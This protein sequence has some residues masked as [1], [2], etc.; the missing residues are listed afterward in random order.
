MDAISLT[1]PCYPA[2]PSKAGKWRGHHPVADDWV[3]EPKLNGWRAW[4]H[5]PTGAMFN[6]HG[7][8]LSIGDTYEEVLDDLRGCSLEWLDSEA[9]ERRHGILR[10]SLVILDSPIPGDYDERQNEI[11]LSLCTLDRFQPLPPYSVPVNDTGKILSFAYTFS[12]KDND[13]DLQPNQ[14]WHRLQEMNRVLGCTFYEGFVAKKRRAPYPR[15][16][17]PE[18]ATT[19]WVKFRWNNA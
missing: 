8:R 15:A 1:P 12:E 13:P 9:L 18:D 6:R 14:A 4:V 3:D 10:A 19:D 17:H 16:R 5:T 2:R 7:D 11:F